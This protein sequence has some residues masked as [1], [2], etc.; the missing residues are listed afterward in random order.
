MWRRIN[1]HN[2]ERAL[3]G[4]SRYDWW[5]FDTFVCALIANACR[6]F[7]L[8]GHGYPADMTVEEWNTYLLE[9]EEPLRVWAEQKFD[10]DTPEQELEAY[11]AAQ[12][13][14]AMFAHRLGSMWD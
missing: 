13:A 3:R 10:F 7:R 1:R 8:Y 12:K 11:R 9:I 14:M 4:Y 5:S 2:S 6:D